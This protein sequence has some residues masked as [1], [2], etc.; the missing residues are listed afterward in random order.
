MMESKPAARAASPREHTQ[1]GFDCLHRRTSTA[2]PGR[3]LRCF[4]TL[5]VRKFSLVLPWDLVCSSPLPPACPRPPPRRAEVAQASCRGHSAPAAA[6]AAASGAA[7]EQSVQRAEKA[8]PLTRGVL[9]P[10]S[11]TLCGSGGP[12]AGSRRQ[13]PAVPQGC[14]CQ[15]T[16][17]P[18]LRARG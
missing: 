5:P 12:S 8:A 13:P 6:S 17:R 7:A 14:P 10:R 18:G 15:G 4:A 16:C 3:L 9:G 1:V 11:Q 2:S